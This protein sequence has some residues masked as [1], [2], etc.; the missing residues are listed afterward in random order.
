MLIVSIVF[1]FLGND[2]IKRHLEGLKEMQLR[3]GKIQYVNLVSEVSLFCFL[4]EYNWLK[5]SYPYKQV[6]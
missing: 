3:H 6:F 5:V 4:D 2:S 1:V